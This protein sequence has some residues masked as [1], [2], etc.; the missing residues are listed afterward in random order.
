MAR[1]ITFLRQPSR[2][3]RLVVEA[4]AGLLRAWFLVSFIPF[5]AYVPGLGTA[6][7]GELRDNV[8]CDL[9]LLGDVRWAIKAVNQ[10]FGDRFTCLMQG[11]AAKAILNRRGVS[12]S[13]VLGAKLGRRDRDGGSGEMAAHAWLWSGDRIILG[14]EAREDF[15]AVTSYRSG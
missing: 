3:K 15:I 12:N 2:R 13:L 5:R 8:M 6:H 10:M 9:D 7:K 14:G 4:F 11:M 1:L